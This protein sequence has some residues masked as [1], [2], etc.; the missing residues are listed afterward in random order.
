MRFNSS[1]LPLSE[2][3]NALRSGELSASGLTEDCITKRNDTLDAYKSWR[4]DVAMSMAA[5]ADQ[6]FS[7]QKDL[8]PLQ[9]IPISLKDL[10][11]VRD[12]EIYAGP[13]RPL[14]NAL[15]REGSLV[16]NLRLPRAVFTG[17]TH[18]VEFAFGGLGVN[19]HWGT[20]RNP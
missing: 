3:A 2:I 6:A 5:L 10:Y 14:P 12:M 13:P 11:A 4:P 19:S 20:P 17:K 7:D 9:G 8:G 1:N 18:T 15:Q 16:E